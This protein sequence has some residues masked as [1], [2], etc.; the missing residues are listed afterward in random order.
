MVLVLGKVCDSDEDVLDLLGS[1][2][3]YN[4]ISANVVVIGLVLLEGR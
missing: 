1:F 4:T 3:L 2:E